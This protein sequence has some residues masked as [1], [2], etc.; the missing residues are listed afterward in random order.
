MIFFAA[1]AKFLSY[2]VIL[3]RTT[4]KVIFIVIPIDQETEAMRN[5][6]QRQQSLVLICGGKV[7]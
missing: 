3:S 1:N 4:R 6:R 2:L 5:G 7:H